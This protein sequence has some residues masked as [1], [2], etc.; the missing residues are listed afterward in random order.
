MSKKRWLARVT[1][2]TNVGRREA[3]SRALQRL[4]PLSFEIRQPTLARSSRDAEWA[5]VGKRLD[6]AVR[7]GAQHR[8]GEGQGAYVAA[9]GAAVT[10]VFKAVPAADEV[11]LSAR[12]MA[13]EASRLAYL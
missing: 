11:L 3:S 1:W 12:Q 6:S 9:A 13:A 7:G 4:P 10:G 8:L 2:S 5:V